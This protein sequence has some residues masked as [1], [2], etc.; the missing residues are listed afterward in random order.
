MVTVDTGKGTLPLAFLLDSDL[1]CFDDVEAL[2]AFFCLAVPNGSK[3][4]MNE[5]F[6]FHGLGTYSILYIRVVLKDLLLRVGKD[7]ALT[8]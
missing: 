5:D 7:P 2:Y 3:V 1:D 6:F 8:I 4:E